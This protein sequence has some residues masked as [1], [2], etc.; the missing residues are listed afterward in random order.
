MSVLATTMNRQIVSGDEWL[1][2]GGITNAH[3]PKFVLRLR[4][5]QNDQ[6]HGRSS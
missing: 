1:D 6:T 4:V 2:V 5:R 3:F